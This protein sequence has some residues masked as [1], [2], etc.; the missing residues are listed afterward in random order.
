MAPAGMAADG[1]WIAGGS[2]G[3]PGY[4]VEQTS[5]SSTQT[6]WVQV[7]DLVDAN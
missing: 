6:T 4:F 3:E 1:W 5:A 7:G 2:A